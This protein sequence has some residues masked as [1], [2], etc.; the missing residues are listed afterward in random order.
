MRQLSDDEKL[1]QEVARDDYDNLTDQ[2]VADLLNDETQIP[3][4]VDSVKSAALWAAIDWSKVDEGTA[5]GLGILMTPPNVQV[6]GTGV[7]A[8]LQAIFGD[9]LNHLLYKT[10]SMRETI[11]Y[12]LPKIGEHHV[13]AARG[14]P[15][16]EIV[17]NVKLPV[18]LAEALIAADPSLVSKREDFEAQGVVRLPL[19]DVQALMEKADSKS[20][21]DVQE[22]L[23][24]RA[25]LSKE[26]V[27][28]SKEQAEQIVAAAEADGKLTEEAAAQLR[29]EHSKDVTID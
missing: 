9:A 13:R 17:L 12:S 26:T 3:V 16:P 23:L 8:Q 4:E 11:G 25:N 27:G 24:L 14:K 20:I 1:A 15:E 7:A 6:R 10:I 18:E 22:Y 2:E 19:A 5:R 29:F 21:S 28:V